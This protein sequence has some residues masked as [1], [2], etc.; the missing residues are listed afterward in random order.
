MTQTKTLGEFIIENQ[1]QFVYS[2]GEL[3]RLLNAIRLAAKT[4]NHEVN[5]AG[6]VDIIGVTDHINR[7]NE[8]QQKLDIFVNQ[9]FKKALTNREIVCGFASEEEEDFVELSCV[10]D[11]TSNN[12]I[13]IID[14]LDGSSNIDTN[15]SIGTIFSIYRRISKPNETLVESDFLQKCKNQVAAG[16]CFVWH[17]YHV[18]LHNWAWG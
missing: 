18:S 4:V 13:V 8:Q 14:P 1:Y 5:K 2:T 12:Y 16:L 11:A 15:V 6:L 17:I 9:A 10:N 7:S 3:S